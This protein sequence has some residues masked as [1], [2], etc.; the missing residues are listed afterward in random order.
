MHNAAG[1]V[2]IRA[3]HI[4]EGTREDICLFHMIITIFYSLALGL[5][6]RELRSGTIFSIFIN[7]LHQDLG[8]AVRRAKLRAIKLIDHYRRSNPQASLTC[9]RVEQGDANI[10]HEK[11]DRFEYRA[12]GSIV[13]QHDPI[14]VGRR[15][16]EGC[17]RP[18]GPAARRRANG[19]C[20]LDKIS[21]P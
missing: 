14:P 11:R 18:P 10:E 16:P 7:S 20:A 9:L 1:F 13:D 19:L 8:S 2:N 5:G 3:G 21:S 4:R 15:H 6:E 17:Q 12:I